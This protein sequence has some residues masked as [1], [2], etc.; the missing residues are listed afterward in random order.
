MLNYLTYL[1]NLGIFSQFIDAERI[2]AKSPPIHLVNNVLI[3][4]ISLF[5]L[6]WMLANLGILFSYVIHHLSCLPGLAGFYLLLYAGYP[7]VFI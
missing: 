1:H 2:N 5:I 7:F 3:G 4:V 6:S